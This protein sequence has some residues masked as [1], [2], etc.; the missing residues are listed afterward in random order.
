MIL[1]DTGY[2]LALLDERDALHPR[3][4]SWAKAIAERLLVSE[5]VLWE[6]MNA[7]SRPTNRPKVHALLAHIRALPAYEIVS[8]SRDLFEA[9]V[10]IHGQRTDK[11]WSLTDCISFILMHER[12]ITRALAH[13]QHFEQAGFEALL[14]R[15]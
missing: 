12:G 14:R 13:D 3:A 6:T 11:E 4:L 5:Y 1:V 7:C 2:L 9:G 15:D 8:A 10:R